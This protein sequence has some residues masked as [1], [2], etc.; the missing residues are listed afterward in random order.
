MRDRMAEHRANPVCATCHKMMDPI[1]FS[2]ENFDAIGRWRVKDGQAKIDPGDTVYDGTKIAG[3]AGLRDFLLSRRQVFVQTMTEKL[4]GYGLGRAL[5]Y[6][7]MP[8]VRAVL[9]DSTREN[10]RFS[11][12]VMGIATSIPFQM[13]MKPADAVDGASAALTETHHVQ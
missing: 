11:S 10:S 2:L 4:M 6:Y 12:I 13:R 8:A 3:A 9:R 5:G 1:G 7:D